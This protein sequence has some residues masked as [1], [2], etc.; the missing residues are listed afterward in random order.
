MTE[1]SECLALERAVLILPVYIGQ[2]D[3]LGWNAYIK[4]ALRTCLNE[5]SPLDQVHCDVYLSS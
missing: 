3:M 2:G 4:A 5:L 1:P